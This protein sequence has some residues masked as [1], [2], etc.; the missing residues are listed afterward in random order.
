VVVW[1]HH[2][3]CIA[4]LCIREVITDGSEVFR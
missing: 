4:E 3:Y 2:L 1:K